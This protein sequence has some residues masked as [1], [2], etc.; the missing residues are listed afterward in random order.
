VLLAFVV[1]VAAEEQLP[2]I[3]PQAFVS[4]PHRADYEPPSYFVK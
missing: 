1:V 3:L 4:W 2:L